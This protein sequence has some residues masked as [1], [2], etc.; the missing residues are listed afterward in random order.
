MLAALVNGV[1][2]GKW[3]SLM[4]KVCRVNVLEKAWEAVK[5]NKGAAGVDKVNIASFESKLDV[6]LAQLSEELSTGKY[7]PLPIKRVEIPK[8]DGKIRPLGI[9]TV[10]DRVVQKAVLMA[11][12]PIFENAFLD[13][14][15]GFRPGRGAQQALSEV[16]KLV[17]DG[18]VNV[19]DADIQ[20]YFDN[21]PHERL[22]S[23]VKEYIAD[24]KVLSVIDGWLH[25]DIMSELERWEPTKGTPQGAVISPLLANLYLHSLDKTVTEAGYKMVRYADDF[26]ILTRSAK[27]AQAALALVE[28][29]TKRNGLTLHPDK[30]H[31]G[32]CRKRGNGFDF[33]GYRFEAGKRSVRKKSL[34]KIKDRIR[35][36]TKR[37]SGRS[38]EV[39]I[40]S[41]NRTLRGWF[42]YFQHAAGSVFRIMDGFVRRRLRALLLRRNKRKG[43]GKSKRCHERWPNAFFASKGLFTMEVKKAKAI[44]ESR[45]LFDGI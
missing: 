11:I 44:E 21:I 34:T 28:V 8:G 39:V 18:Y 12:E 3:Y 35:E 37:N 27:S 24:G 14:S 13:M 45:S 32:N 17:N 31:V 23:R 1:K 20:G 5:R 42:G 2:G 15:Y 29:W 40:E 26:V 16:E 33:L 30:V 7:K 9:P 6:K 19:V 41:L 25:Q 38:L 4:D 43:F 36:I 10:R 22:M